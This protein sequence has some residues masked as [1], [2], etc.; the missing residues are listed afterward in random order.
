M[1]DMDGGFEYEMFCIPNLNK[2]AYVAHGS[3]G[4]KTTLL[5]QN[6]VTGAINQGRRFPGYTT[7]VE[8]ESVR[9]Y[10][11]L[12]RLVYVIENNQVTTFLT[13]FDT[14]KIKFNAGSTQDE[15]DV[16]VTIEVFNKGGKQTFLQLATIYPHA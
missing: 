5:N 11:F 16:Q 12:D 9:A 1:E 4:L 6:A 15:T 13:T 14:P 8:A 10:E 3:K 2:V 7:N